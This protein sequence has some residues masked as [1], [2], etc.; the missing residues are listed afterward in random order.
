MRN[1][2]N[3]ME[4]QTTLP[5]RDEREE[6]RLLA[7]RSKQGD[8]GAYE[9]LL[10]RVYERIEQFVSNRIRLE[11]LREDITQDI[12]L[13]VHLSLPSY[14]G[15]DSFTAWLF[16]IARRRLIDFM[17]KKKRHT[18]EEITDGPWFELQ[19]AE[20]EIAGLDCFLHELRKLPEG[21]QRV[22]EMIHLEGKSTEVASGELGITENNLR[23]T[24]HRAVQELKK[25]LRENQ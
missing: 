1:A 11:E 10:G 8:K 9:E 21:K 16:T 25:K 3:T 14:S 23:V 22:V 4:S 2:S 18:V 19:P 5:R 12:I 17:R 7:V 13:S 24:L 15:V 20:E 6:L